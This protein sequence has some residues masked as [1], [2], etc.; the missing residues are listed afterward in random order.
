MAACVDTG[1]TLQ[2]ACVRF[3][4]RWLWGRETQQTNV[5]H[6]DATKPMACAHRPLVE[7]LTWYACKDQL[8]NCNGLVLEQA[9]PVCALDGASLRKHSADHCAA[10]ARRK[11]LVCSTALQ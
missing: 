10:W 3:W 8:V 9:V 11:T 5:Q 1:G 2:T 7:A 6:G 4:D